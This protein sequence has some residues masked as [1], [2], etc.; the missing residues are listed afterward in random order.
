[1]FLKTMKL[2]GLSLDDL[3]TYAGKYNGASVN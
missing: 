2:L 3:K 1:M